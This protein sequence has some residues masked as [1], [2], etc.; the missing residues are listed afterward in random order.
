MKRFELSEFE[1]GW[2]IGNFNPSIFHNREFEIAVKRYNTGETEHKH[3]QKTATEVTF[4]VSGKIRMNEE[5]L[6]GNQIIELSPSEEYDFEALEK[7]VLVCIKYPS[8]PED[9]IISNLR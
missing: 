6:V 8:L 2:I 7:T 9:K 1:N 4:V 3:F 5:I